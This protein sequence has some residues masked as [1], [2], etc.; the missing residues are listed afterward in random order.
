MAIVDAD[1]GQ[2]AEESDFLARGFVHD[3]T[4]FDEVVPLIEKAL[5]KAAEEG[6]GGAVQLEQLIARAVGRW[7]DRAYRRSPLIIPIV[8]D[9]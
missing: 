2:L 6:V 5:A 1:T 4:T 8:I 3:E 9:A 7:A